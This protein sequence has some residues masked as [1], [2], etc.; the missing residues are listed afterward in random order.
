MSAA[1]DPVGTLRR[2]RG[3]AFVH[4]IKLDQGKNFPCWDL[5]DAYGSCSEL[6]GDLLTNEEVDKGDNTVVY[7]PVEAEEWARL[8]GDTQ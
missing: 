3:N 2:E 7:T 1:D 5:I 6:L 4:L 8:T